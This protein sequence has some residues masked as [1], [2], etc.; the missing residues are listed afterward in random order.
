VSEQERDKKFEELEEMVINLREQLIE[1]NEC[2]DAVLACN[3]LYRTILAVHKNR[4]DIQ[5][6]EKK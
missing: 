4:S 1:D 2:S 3:D 5:E 6:A